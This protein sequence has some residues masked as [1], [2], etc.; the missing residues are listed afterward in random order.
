[1]NLLSVP[2]PSSALNGVAGKYFFYVAQMYDSDP[3]KYYRT[4][5]NI[6]RG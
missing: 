2:N 1:M 4:A 6:F 3:R 5:L